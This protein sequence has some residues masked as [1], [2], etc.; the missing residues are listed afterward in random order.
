M[1]EENANFNIVFPSGEEEKEG[2]GIQVECT[3]EFQFY[4]QWI[5][6]FKDLKH[7]KI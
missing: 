2:N 1:W 3:K 4:L 7:G 6:I 5:V